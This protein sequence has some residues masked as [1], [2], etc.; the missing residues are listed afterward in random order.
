MK[1]VQPYSVGG[2]KK[3]LLLAVAVLAGAVVYQLTASPPDVPPPQAHA[4]P[5]APGHHDKEGG[6]PHTHG[7]H[8]HHGGE[9]PAPVAVKRPPA[10]LNAQALAAVQAFARLRDLPAGDAAIELGQQLEA[11]ITADNTA[12]YVQTLLT[13]QNRAVERAAIAALARSANGA[14]MQEIAAEYGALPPEQRGRILQV[15]EGAANPA[16]WQGL[17][18]IAASDTSEKRSPV[19]MSALSGVANIGSVEAVQYLLSQLTPGNADFALMALRRVRSA[20]GIEMIRA[21][22]QGSKDTSGLAPGFREA[23][24]QLSAARQ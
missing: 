23:L 4:Q 22:A 18:S 13:T 14:V 11:G 17:A 9:P 19:V 5:A 1:L 24:L 7:A 10:P 6:A 16:A 12:G 21:A 2:M 8:D 3:P 20:Q 15:L